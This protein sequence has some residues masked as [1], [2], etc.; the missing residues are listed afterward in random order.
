MYEYAECL[1]VRALLKMCKL[2]F[3]VEHR[4]NAQFMSPSGKRRVS[5][6]VSYVVF[7]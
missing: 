6:V 3:R 5:P 1:A 7:N 2:P 4:T